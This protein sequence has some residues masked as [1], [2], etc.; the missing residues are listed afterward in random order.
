MW[1]V[2]CKGGKLAN[3]S[4]VR[5]LVDSSRHNISFKLSYTGSHKDHGELLITGLFSLVFSHKIISISRKHV[6]CS[7]KNDIVL[8]INTESRPTEIKKIHK[9]LL[10]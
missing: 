10:F 3:G 5:V 4:R 2:R 1:W 8:H 6:M 7:R 9:Q